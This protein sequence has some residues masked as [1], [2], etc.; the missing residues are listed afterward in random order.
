MTSD[1]IARQTENSFPHNRSII[2][3]FRKGTWYQSKDLQI[4]SNNKDTAVSMTSYIMLADDINWYKKCIK[5]KKIELV[6]LEERKEIIRKA[7]SYF[8]EGD[9]DLGPYGIQSFNNF[10]SSLWKQ[11]GLPYNLVKKWAYL[12]CEVMEKQLNQKKRYN[13]NNYLTLVSLP[14]NTFLCL[15]A[16]L[17]AFLEGNFV[18]IRP[19]F[20]EPFSALRMIGCLIKAGL[21]NH[22]FSFYPCNYETLDRI[23]YMMDRAILY[24]GQK[25]VEIYGN[26]KN[27]DVHGP[28][29]AAL[30]VD[31]YTDQN[32][33]L[34]WMT[35]KIAGNAGRF[36]TNIGTILFTHDFND[37]SI[38]LAKNLDAIAL[39]DREEEWPI[40]HWQDLNYVN[41]I[42]CY[43]NNLLT[44]EDSFLTKRPLV[45]LDTNGRPILAPALVKLKN[46]IES[47]LL[48]IE[49]PFPFTVIGNVKEI[50]K[51]LKLLH[52]SKFVYL[53][54]RNK[55]YE[56]NPITFEKKEIENIK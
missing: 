18:I 32:K 23:I 1:S 39:S 30:V 14:S 53:A 54:E 21:N 34:D 33:L 27:I 11:N 13:E 55:I 15:E 16:S 6:G 8:S 52:D 3:I 7:L 42:E 56:V 5:E 37:L 43:I 51:A 46:P 40:T 22:N 10:C 29:R 36:C 26:K 38:Q 17:M 49:L 47:K 48:G 4:L 25:I 41:M 45:S 9:I 24:G 20:E 44:D 28:G 19:S 35:Y 50:E 12:L 31:S 2:P